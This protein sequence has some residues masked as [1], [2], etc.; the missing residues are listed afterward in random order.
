VAERATFVVDDGDVVGL[1]EAVGHIA[2]AGYSEKTVRE[3]LGLRDIC[4]LQMRSLPIYREERLKARDALDLLIELFLFQGAITLDELN[5]LPIASDQDL[6]VR[7]GVLSLDQ[8]GYARG[9]ASLFPV[10]ERLIFSDHVWPELSDRLD[11]AVP[12]DQV[13]SVGVDSRWLARATVRRPVRNTLD[14]CTG[15]GVQALLSTRHSQRVVAI[16]I[17]SRATRCAR[18][19]ARAA[20]A[21]NLELAVGDLFEPVAGQRFDLITANPPFVPSPLH[22]LG[23]RDGGRSGEDVQKRIV[24][25]LPAHLAAGGIAQMVT[26]LG[27][28]DDEPIVDRLRDWLGGAPLDIYVLRLRVYSV[29]SYAIGHAKGD[30]HGSFLASVRSWAGN[31]T[32][33]G[34]SQVVSVLVAFEWSDRAL[35]AAWS[36]VDEAKP[37]HDD[38]GAE[39]EAA[40]LAQRLIRDPDLDRRVRSGWLHRSGP[41]ALQEARVLGSDVGTHIRATRLGRSLPVEHVLTATERDLLDRMHGR[42]VASDVAKMGQDLRIDDDT[43]WAAIKSLVGCGLVAVGE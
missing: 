9:R 11:P 8:C 19:N 22:A 20:G 30:D 41:I 32:A 16:D 24:A 5:R 37:P 36:R 26:E 40:F 25:G 35:G 29:A 39:I 42:V 1:R 27:E 13:M 15:S 21:T 28:R 18:F 38:A 23:F 12:H 43:V 33:Q 14:L 10:G 34:Y 31:L 4:D 6:L 2:L 7:A 17:N 3:R